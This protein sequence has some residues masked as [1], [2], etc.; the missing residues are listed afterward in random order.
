MI[1]SSLVFVESAHEL[2][3]PELSKFSASLWAD[4]GITDAS[5]LFD[6]TSFI[7]EDIIKI[8]E[9][10]VNIETPSRI[11]KWV[12]NN[13][14]WW[15]NGLISDID[16]INGIQYLVDKGIII[17]NVKNF[18]Y[19]EVVVGTSI[20]KYLPYW[21]GEKWVQMERDGKIVKSES[22]AHI[23]QLL[24]ETDDKETRKTLNDRWKNEC[25]IG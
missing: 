19:G 22:C 18:G 13:A 8:P 14:G 25:V 11:P 12:K 4:D 3:I 23:V 10:E 15:A 9:T 21:L 1:T 2:V 5:Y 24:Y 6:L 20:P 7:R 17:I 16:Y